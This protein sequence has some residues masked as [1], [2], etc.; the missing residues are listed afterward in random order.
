MI[1]IIFKNINT[2]TRIGV[3]NFKGESEK[4]TLSKFV[5]KSK[6]LLDEIY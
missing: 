2:A 1:Y 5:K 4:A 3:F 6:Y